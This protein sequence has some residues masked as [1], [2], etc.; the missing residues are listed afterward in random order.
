MR[1]GRTALTA[2]GTFAGINTIDCGVVRTSRRPIV[3]TRDPESVR[4][5][6]SNARC[7]PTTLHRVEAKQRDVARAVQQEAG[8]CLGRWRHAGVH[9]SRGGRVLAI[10][11]NI[12]SLRLAALELFKRHATISGEC[13][14]SGMGLRVLILDERY[15]LAT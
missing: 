3:K 12:S 14:F 5:S 10:P 2:C 8:D 4:T 13:S 11:F 15:R 6:A 7:A 9:G 1:G